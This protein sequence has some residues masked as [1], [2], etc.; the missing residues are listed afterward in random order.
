MELMKTT[1]VSAA[2]AAEAAAV[3]LSVVL[4]TIL[5]TAGFDRAWIASRGPTRYLVVKLI[6]EVFSHWV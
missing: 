6:L 5:V 1:A 3:A 2:P 4:E